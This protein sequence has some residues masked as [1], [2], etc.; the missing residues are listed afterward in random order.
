MASRPKNKIQQPSQ[1]SQN[2]FLT[3][4]TK[5]PRR[6]ARARSKFAHLYTVS[7]SLVIIGIIIGLVLIARVARVAGIRR[8]GRDAMVDSADSLPIVSDALL[9]EL[10]VGCGDGLRVGHEDL[11]VCV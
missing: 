8:I 6:H 10:L 11:E 5:I 3:Q 7:F 2:S 1:S 9:V 4:P